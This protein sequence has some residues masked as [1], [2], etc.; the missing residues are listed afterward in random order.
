MIIDVLG[1]YL[2]D[3]S[4]ATKEIVGEKSGTFLQ[5]MQRSLI[6][7]TLNIARCFKILA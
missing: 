7:S 3:M 2:A 1:G 4:Q 5:S 6:S